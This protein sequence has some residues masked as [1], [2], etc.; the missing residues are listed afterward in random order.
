MRGRFS[1]SMFTVAF[2]AVAASAAI[3][4]FIARTSGQTPAARPRG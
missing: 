3:S 4:V 2:A 1:R